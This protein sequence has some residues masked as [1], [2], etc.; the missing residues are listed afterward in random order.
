[1]ILVIYLK[2]VRSLGHRPVTVKKAVIQL[3]EWVEAQHNI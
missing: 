2:T 1:M 3:K